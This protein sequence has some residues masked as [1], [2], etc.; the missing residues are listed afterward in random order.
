MKKLTSLNFQWK[1]VNPYFL[2]CLH[3]SQ[4]GVEVKLDLQLYQIDQR[5]YLLD[6]KVLELTK[7]MI[8]LLFY[9]SFKVVEALGE[10]S[11]GECKAK[12]HTMEFFEAC[13][14]LIGAL[15]Q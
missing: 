4:T 11:D 7:L 5:N 12:C 9:L 14:K 8:N 6:F 15:A 13:S 2:R 1:V 10:D 3:V